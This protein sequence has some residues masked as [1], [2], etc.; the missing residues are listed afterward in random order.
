MARPSAA[1]ERRKPAY[2][3]DPF[4][5][6]A[7]ERLVHDHHRRVAEHG[8]GDAETLTHAQRV[9]AGLAAGR[10]AEADE[11]DHLVDPARGQSLGARHP[12]QVVASGPAGLQG[13]RR[14]RSAPTWR[15]GWRRCW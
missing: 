13:G 7:V 12:Q 2:P 10:R 15:S 14:P 1:S 6:H 3:D 5:V 8:R 9:A 11:L 4:G